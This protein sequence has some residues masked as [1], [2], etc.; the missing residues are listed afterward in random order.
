MRRRDLILASGAL[1]AAPLAGAQAPTRTYRV[2]MLFP[3][4]PQ[5]ASAHLPAFRERM[6]QL[7]FVEG[8]N[9]SLDFRYPTPGTPPAAAAAREL[10][11]LKPDVLVACTTSAALGALSGSK[12]VPV[13]FAW[14]A[15]PVSFGLVK[16][17]SRPGGRATGVTNRFYELAIKRLELVRELLPNARRIATLAVYFDALLEKYLETAQGP[18]IKLGLELVRQQASP[19]GWPEALKES[20]R[21]GAEAAMILTPFGIFGM[22]HDADET[23]RAA[24]DLRLPAVYGEAESVERGGLMSYATSLGED[25]RRAADLVAKILRGANPAELPVDQ[26]AR[27]ELV[28]NRGTAQAMGLP[29]PQSLLLRADRVIE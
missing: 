20:M 5:T 14:V 12:T 7:G 8:R 19:N 6:A 16:T 28:V 10:M 27:F 2:G 13:V 24:R 22:H 15:D 9:L 4:S 3:N 25:L 18:A 17:F 29:L 23:T 11:E 26:A 21:Q 1:L